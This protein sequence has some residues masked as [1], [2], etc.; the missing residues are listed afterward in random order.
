MTIYRARCAALVGKLR[1]PCLRAE[2]AAS[3]E[4]DAVC[5][6]CSHKFSEHE[7][8]PLAIPA[9]T[10]IIDPGMSVATLPSIVDAR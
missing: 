6:Q 4:L 7:D 2:A 1:C 5:D 8:L 10:D 9:V 3:E